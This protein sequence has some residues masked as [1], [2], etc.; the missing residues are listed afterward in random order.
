M[1]KH[2]RRALAM[3]VCL[4][5]VIGI[6]A[7]YAFAED[8]N[9]LTWK[10]VEQADSSDETFTVTYT[11][12][13][14][15]AWFADEVHSDLK[16]GDP[17][18]KYNNGVNPTRDGYDFIG[19]SPEVTDTVTGNATYTAQW[20]SKSE[21]LIKEL[22]G[23][24]TVKCIKE[25]SGH[26][27]KEYDTSVG[28]FSAIT[29]E[30]KKG[31]FTSTITVDAAKYVKKYN[32]EI[33]ATHRL[34]DGEKETQTIV[35]EFNSSYS[36]DSVTVESGTLPVTFKVTCAETVPE[37]KYTVTYTDGVEGEEVFKEQTYNVESGTATPA[38]NDG[39]NPVREG[40]QFKGWSPVVADTVTGNVIYTAQWQ[41]YKKPS[42]SGIKFKFLYVDSNL[43]NGYQ[44][45]ELT[46]DAKIESGSIWEKGIQMDANGSRMFDCVCSQCA[47]DATCT[48]HKMKA[49]DIRLAA[50]RAQNNYHALKSGYGYVGWTKTAGSNPNITAFSSSSAEADS[51]EVTPDETIIYFVAK[52]LYTVTYT[53]GVEGEE[54]FEDQ[55]YSA[56]YGTATPAFNG[57]PARDGY[58]FAGWNPAVADTVT[59][60]VTYTAEWESNEYVPVDPAPATGT[61]TV[62]KT[63]T[64]FEVLPEG[65]NVTINVKQGDKVVRTA[66]LS[67]FTDGK[68]TYSFYGLPAGTY[69]VSET[70]A[71]VDG[72]KLEATADQTVTVTA[73]G[74][75][76]AAF[77]NA[78]TKAEEPVTPD[79]PENPDVPD[80]PD[81]PEKP[82][83]PE[84]PKDNAVKTGDTANTGIAWG[85]FGAALLGLGGFAVRRRKASK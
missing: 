59:K 75:A 79:D 61:L 35:V 41:K 14:G 52:P 1:K 24:I 60:T 58:K 11:D 46:E 7:P 71:D 85:V 2:I 69:T 49:V 18:P 56:A 9:T 39:K 81:K 72:Y 53:D 32:D 8:N 19:W 3:A 27:A 4:I 47:V 20:E 42:F 38:F 16:S 77:V 43:K 28:G 48:I 26:A 10:L 73:G 34:A 55:I 21:I 74:T 80:K 40:Y 68:A 36:K 82:E 17:T 30:K 78:Y 13:R 45:V 33:N 64:G 29:L 44:V 50:Q 66:T 63:V 57:T 83:K 12:G 70:A 51:T 23:K 37:E 62:T 15:G 25:G 31:K 5:M 76:T 67:S 84:T 54:V 22:L 6:M 65:Y